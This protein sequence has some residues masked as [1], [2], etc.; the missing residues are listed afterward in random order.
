MRIFNSLFCDMASA[1]ALF[2]AWHEFRRGKTERKDVLEFGRHVERNIF[3]L[4][5]E[6]VSRRYKH[7]AYDSFFIHDPK[8]RHIRKAQVRDRIV[9]QAAYTVLT[10]TYEPKLIHHVYS[11]RLGFGTHRAVNALQAMTRKV[12]K[13]LTRPCWALKCDIKKFYDTVDHEILQRLLG[14]T[15]HDEAALWLLREIIG[16]FHT[17]GTPGKGI[18]IGNLTSQVF[19]NIYL[20]EFDQFAKHTL[21]VKHYLRFAD[22]MIFL[23]PT[24]GE[25][26]ELLNKVRAFLADKLRLE[27]HPQKIVISP[28]H[29]GIDFLGYVTLPHHRVLRTKT[30]RRMRRK[31]SERLK[32]YFDGATPDDS[33]NQTLQSYLGM[34]SH[35]DTHKLQEEIKNTFCWG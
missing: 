30:G 14:R 15:I 18:P 17:E 26:E 11:S 6:L 4:H 3:C 9:H 8:V 35:A 28:L 2:A 23:A 31:L 33:M 16:S 29:Q 19:T 32:G 22:D 5:R 10:R 20:N 7:S 25:L 34:L 1:E 24:R 13:N 27:L 21:R 12:S